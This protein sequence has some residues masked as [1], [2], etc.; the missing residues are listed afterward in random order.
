MPGRLPE[1]S[2]VGAF[3]LELD[4]RPPQTGGAE[5]VSPQCQVLE[6]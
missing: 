1:V 2:S 3:P 4:P 6:P 5:Q